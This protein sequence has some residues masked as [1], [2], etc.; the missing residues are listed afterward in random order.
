MPTITANK[1]EL[2]YDETG[3][4]DAPVIIL[5]MGLGT[6]MIAWPD[7]FVQGLAD[8]GFRVIRFDNRDIGLSTHLDGAASPNLIWTALATKLGL[9]VGVAYSLKDMAADTIGMMDALGIKKAHIAGASMGGMIAQNVAALYPDRVLSLIS[10][11]SSS[12][13]SG[14]PGPTSE[15]RKRMMK[16][17]PDASQRAEAIA[18]GT[19]MQKLISFPDPA[20]APDALEQLVTTAFD[21]SYYPT[22][23]R[24]QLLAILTDTGRPARLAKVTAP[25]LV[26]HGAAD[27]LV[28]LANSVDIAQRVPGARL[29]V[30]DDMAHDLPPSQVGRMVSLIAEHAKAA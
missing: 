3:A 6:Q 26:I 1:M 19:G 9:P 4:A 25:T 16:P 24:R 20:R 27:P 11:M 30:I 29:E 18:A 28:P 23:A 21:R 12:G 5:I 15:L 7:V 13:A 22:G 8:Q 17:R 2:F 10:I 14:L